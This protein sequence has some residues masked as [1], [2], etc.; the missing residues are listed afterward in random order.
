MDHI[1]IQTISISYKISEKWLLKVETHLIGG[2]RKCM[3]TIQQILN[4]KEVRYHHRILSVSHSFRQAHAYANIHAQKRATWVHPIT[5]TGTWENFTL[6]KS[7]LRTKEHSSTVNYSFKR[8]EW[9]IDGGGGDDDDKKVLVIK[10]FYL[11]SMMSIL[12]YSKN[13]VS[14]QNPLLKFIIKTKD[15]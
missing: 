2:V 7:V 8:R 4:S 6:K 9:L 5:G 13:S 14:Q 10:F 12:I 15:I 3:Q 1:I 11:Y